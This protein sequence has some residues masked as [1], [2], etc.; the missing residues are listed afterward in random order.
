MNISP[1][2]Y[3]RY[4]HLLSSLY[5]DTFYSVPDTYS[6]SENKSRLLNLRRIYFFTLSANTIS[7][8]TNQK[9]LYFNMYLY[10]QTHI[11]VNMIFYCWM[12]IAILYGTRKG[13]K[14]IVIQEF[15]FDK[16]AQYYWKKNREHTHTCLF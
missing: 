10:T 12:Y 6:V 8:G 5:V 14:F 2:L 13:I 1:I 7:H 9:P 16:I 3:T 11:K 15:F 4:I